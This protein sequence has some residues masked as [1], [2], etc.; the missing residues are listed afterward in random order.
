VVTLPE[1][2]CLHAHKAGGFTFRTSDGTFPTKGFAV[3]VAKGPERIIARPLLAI[4]IEGYLAEMDGV[5]RAGNVVFNGGVCI[6]A[7]RDGD[8]WYLDLSIVCRS[9]DEALTLGRQNQ[10]LSVYDLEGATS[11]AIPY[12]A[13]PAEVAA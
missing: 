9:L 3:A 12:H 4:D 1:L 2:L 7:W 10:Q 11:I 6:G 8:R 5:I 13:A